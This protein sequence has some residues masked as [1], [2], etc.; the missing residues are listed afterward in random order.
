MLV[1]YAPFGGYVNMIDSSRQAALRESIELLFFAY[2]AFTARPD[3][4]LGQRGLGRVHH[5]VLYFVARNPG[6]GISGLLGILA[7]SK[8]ALNG[9]LRQLA[10]MNLVD[11]RPAAHDGRVKQLRLSA[12]GERLERQLTGTQMRQLASVFEHAGAPAERAWR[13]VMR[14]LAGRT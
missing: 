10:E 6:I 9:P 11:I 3:R 1:L 14:A 8:Q 4:I 7:V 12:E 5:R 2:R 13:D